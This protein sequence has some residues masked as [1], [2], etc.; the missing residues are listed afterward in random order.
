MEKFLT[1][2]EVADILGVAPG[3]VENWRYKQEGPAYV[4]LGTKRSSLVRYRLADVLAYIDTLPYSISQET[5]RGP[6]L[7]PEPP[8]HSN[9]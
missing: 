8:S 2:A 3:T 4:K 1:T 7:R 5:S 9:P 6:G